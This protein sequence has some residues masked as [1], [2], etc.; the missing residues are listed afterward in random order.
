M[1]DQRSIGERVSLSDPF[2]DRRSPGNPGLPL[3]GRDD[4]I[5][6]CSVSLIPLVWVDFVET[7]VGWHENDKM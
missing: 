1:I 7:G 4:L 2:R 5:G 3:T 6:L